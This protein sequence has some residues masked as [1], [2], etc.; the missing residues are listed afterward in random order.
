M[1]VYKYTTAYKGER[2]II[3]LLEEVRDHMPDG[4]S[5]RESKPAQSTE[6]NR[7]GAIHR[8]LTHQ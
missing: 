7:G 6:T 8:Y 4:V 5:K 1:R 3:Y 2:M